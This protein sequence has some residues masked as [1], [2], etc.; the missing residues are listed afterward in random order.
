MIIKPIETGYKGYRFRSRLEARWAV[1][2]DHLGVK[3]E[4]E[5]EG[6]D[7][8]RDL[9]EML[10]NPET[11]INRLPR[12]KWYLPDFWLPEIQFWAEVK[13]APFTDQEAAMC[14]AL[15]MLTDRNVLMLPGQPDYMAYRFY[16]GQYMRGGF[17]GGL[18]SCLLTRDY[19]IENRLYS[20]HSK[21]GMNK[22]EQESW[23]KQDVRYV[24]AVNAARSARF[25]FGEQGRERFN[26][27]ASFD[28]K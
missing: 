24:Q 6:Y 12:N 5:K 27:S 21:I 4:Y 22:F 2:F 13:G 1:F 3:W 10:I 25:E 23:L 17:F 16:S 7:L 18:C 19:L 28:R 11:L 26:A 14:Q 20:V 9:P 8:G 15:A